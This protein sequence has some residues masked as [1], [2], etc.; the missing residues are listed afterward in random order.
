MY[1]C[2]PWVPPTWVKSVLSSIR[3]QRNKF[4]ALANDISEMSHL[5]PFAADKMAGI[6]I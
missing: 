6:R 3:G 4:T 1:P 5:R 2:C